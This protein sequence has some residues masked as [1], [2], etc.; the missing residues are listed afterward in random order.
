M[1]SIILVLCS[2]FIH[3]FSV[4]AQNEGLFVSSDGKV[5]IGTS[6]PSEVL[7]VKSTGA[8]FAAIE[9]NLGH[10]GGFKYQETGETESVWFFPY[11]RGWQSD[12]LIIRDEDALMDVMTFQNNTGNVGIGISTP[13]VKLNINGGNDISLSGGGYFLVGDPS[14]TNIGMDNNEIMSRNGG[15]TSPLYLN[16][17]G[18]DVIINEITGNVGIGTNSPSQ[19]LHVDGNL[20]V[21]GGIT[22]E[23]DTSYITIAPGDFTPGQESYNYTN[24]GYKLFNQ[25]GTSAYFHASVS[26]PDGAEIIQFTTYWIDYSAVNGELALRRMSLADGTT[27]T[28]ADVITF[29]NSGN[30]LEKSASGF[31]GPTTVDAGNYSYFLVLFLEASSAVEFYGVRIKYVTSA[32]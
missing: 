22:Y 11:F 13:S 5:G 32:L 27:T 31:V 25:A 10:H 18:G 24:N 20:H 8:T 17:E 14:L 28:I 23:N 16:R 7:H 4:T 9:R 3:C 15:A 26:I 21:D 12:N 1:K 2:L 29:A 30:W 19:K 6:N